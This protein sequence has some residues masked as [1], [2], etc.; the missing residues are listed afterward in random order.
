MNSH[1][2]TIYDLK[3]YTEL[4]KFQINKFYDIQKIGEDSFAI[5]TSDYNENYKIDFFKIV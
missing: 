2:I 4:E 3:D 5:I 1:Y